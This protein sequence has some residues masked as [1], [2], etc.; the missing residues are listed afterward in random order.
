MQKLTL[1][2]DYLRYRVRSTSPQDAEMLLT[3]Q[4]LPTFIK[5]LRYLR[6]VL[7]WLQRIRVI[8]L[9][10][11]HDRSAL[12]DFH[13]KYFSLLLLGSVPK[14]VYLS[15]TKQNRQSVTLVFIAKLSSLTNACQASQHFLDYMC[16]KAS[17]SLICNN[18]Y[19]CESDWLKKKFKMQ[20]EFFQY[21]IIIN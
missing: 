1:Q 14:Q 12:Q 18:N 8:L 4:Q 11:S 7:M 21:S 16:G 20:K 13:Y 19:Y 2:H 9:H 17:F 6:C 3:L 15:N 5:L 10:C